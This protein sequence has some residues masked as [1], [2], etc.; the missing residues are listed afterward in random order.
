MVAD[1]LAD[2]GHAVLTA[3]DGKEALERPRESRPEVIV[4]DLMRLDG[5]E[6][7]DRYQAVAGIGHSDRRR[8]GGS[9]CRSSRLRQEGSSRGSR[10][11]STSSNWRQPSATGANRRM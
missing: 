6:F 3:R 11:H 7:A 9:Q 10:N 2:R 5:W 1:D 4:L 8:F